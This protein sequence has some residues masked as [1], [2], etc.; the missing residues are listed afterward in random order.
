MPVS[1][2]E[3]KSI[4]ALR[5]KSERYSQGLFVVEGV[6]MVGELLAAEFP[7][8]RIYATRDWEPAVEYDVVRVS[9]SELSR[10][11]L[12]KTPN[13]V[14]AVARIP[15]SGTADLPDAGLHLYLDRVSDPG[16]LGTIVRMADWFGLDRV[17]CSPGS[18]DPY[19]PKTVQSSMGSIFRVRVVEAG[20]EALFAHYR[21]DVAGGKIIGAGM[22]G[23]QL[24]GAAF[25]G[26]CLLVMG[27]ESHGIDNQIMAMCDKVLTIPQRGRAESLNV[28]AATAIFLWEYFR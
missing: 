25:N 1:R 4:K 7:V 16:N 14:L 18:V 26:N 19:N 24:S 22:K 10:M 27:S 8:E 11:S 2:N 17:F 5:S 28:A 20:A 21:N 13:S 15:E 9:D 3:I 6:K 12:L 23:E